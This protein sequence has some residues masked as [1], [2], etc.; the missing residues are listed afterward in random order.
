MSWQL[1]HNGPN[2]RQPPEGASVR[3]GLMCCASRPS[4]RAHSARCADAKR[5]HINYDNIRDF[6]IN[7]KRSGGYSNL[8]YDKKIMEN[9]FN[10]PFPYHGIFLMQ[11]NQSLVSIVSILGLFYFLVVL[12]NRVPI[13]NVIDLRTAN[14]LFA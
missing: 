4:T 2:E 11:R 9:N 8:F 14:A 6:I 13:V 5:R 10:V 7:G 12:S 3:F 1:S